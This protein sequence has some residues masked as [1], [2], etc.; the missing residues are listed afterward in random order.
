MEITMPRGDLRNVK[1]NITDSSGEI[2]TTIFDE[3]YI[4]FK[5]NYIDE[6]V[7]FQKKLSDGTI[8]KDEESYYHFK[9]EPED[10][11][12]LKYK[13][14]VFDIELIIENSVKQTTL[15]KLMITDEVTFATNEGE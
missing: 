2:V 10:T 11:N 7:I 14:Y 1:F 5:E 15:G 6:K 13:E 3:I 8:T 4:T 9:I 12:K